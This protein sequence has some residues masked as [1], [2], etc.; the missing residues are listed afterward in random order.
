MKTFMV[1]LMGFIGV[2]TMYSQDKPASSKYA[3]SFGMAD[4][5]RLDKFNGSIAVKKIIDD[6][7]QL[8]LFLIPSFSTTAEQKSEQG[9]SDKNTHEYFNFSLGIGTDYLWTL[10]NN[11]DVNMFGGSGVSFTY[12]YYQDKS[13]LKNSSGD[14]YMSLQKAPFTEMGIRSVLGVEWRV[15][16]KI[17]I[18][19]EYLMSGLYSW[20]KS[21]TGLTGGIFRPTQ[22]KTTNKFT[23]TSSV[24]FGVSIYL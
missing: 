24:L 21:E 8:R 1:I 22:T 23:I 16:T 12:G 6:E 14:E 10:M 4:N 15:N 3:L 17:G 9:N 7:H 11:G 20:Q 19:S 13:I 5:F 18:H 2:S